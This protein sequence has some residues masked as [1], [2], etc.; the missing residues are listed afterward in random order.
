MAITSQTQPPQTLVFDKELVLVTHRPLWL[1]EQF[2]LETIGLPYSTIIEAFERSTPSPQ[3]A[4][5]RDVIERR[6]IKV[7]QYDIIFLSLCRRNAVFVAPRS[8]CAIQLVQP[9]PTTTT[10]YEGGLAVAHVARHD[11]E[12][13]RDAQAPSAYR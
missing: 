4:T 11:C 1:V 3:V 5:M 2:F 13:H 12:G 6:I 9:A 10:P 8:P 7:R